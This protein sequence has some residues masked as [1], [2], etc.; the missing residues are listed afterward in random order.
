MRQID[1]VPAEAIG[2]EARLSSDLGIDSLGRVELLGM[3]E[4]DLG[5]FIDDGEL[6]PDET[7]GGLQAR[8]DAA[9]PRPQRRRREAASSAGL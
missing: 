7:V 5:V 3:V 8:V 2:P 9:P 6:D 1:G 4:E